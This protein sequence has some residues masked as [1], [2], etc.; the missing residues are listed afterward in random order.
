MALLSTKKCFTKAQIGF[1][2]VSHTLRTSQKQLISINFNRTSDG[3][4]L[5]KEMFYQSPNWFWACFK[6]NFN[7]FKLVQHGQQILLHFVSPKEYEHLAQRKVLYTYVNK[8]M[9]EQGV[10]E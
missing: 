7:I 10:V 1:G 5:H 2:L 9:K 6:T 4:P 8:T 3:T